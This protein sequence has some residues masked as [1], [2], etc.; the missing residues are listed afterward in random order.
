MAVAF[1]FS[2]IMAR[3]QNVIKKI[4]PHDSKERY[5]ALGVDCLTG[6]AKITSP[7]A[8]EVD[9]KILTTRNITIACGAAPFVPPIP[10]LKDIPYL[11]SE[12]IWRRLLILGGGPIGCELAQAFCRLG[13]KITMVEM[14][15]RIL[16][17]EDSE[18]SEHIT[19]Q[20]LFEG[21][22][23]LAGH[24][25]TSFAMRD[26]ATILVAE[27]NGGR[28]EIEFD[29]VLIAVGRKSRVTGYGLEELGIELR[30][31][32]TIEVNEFLETKYP[33]IFACG[34]VTG[35]FQFTHIAA[36]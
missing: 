7:W 26:G 12:T 13:S 34:D 30:P 17:V 18:V 2:E 8:I 28:Q 33:N 22:E 20:F 24:K 25:A 32:A 31:N 9:K 29:Q 3:V 6:T 14:L 36:H 21:I 5:Q 4:E 11:T 1:D 19:S 10:G 27:K 23:V 35:P 16:A 15:D